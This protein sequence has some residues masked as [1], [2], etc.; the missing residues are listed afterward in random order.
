MTKFWFTEKKK[1]QTIFIF[2]SNHIIVALENFNR[3]VFT[4][5][6]QSKNKKIIIIIIIQIKS[7]TNCGWLWISFRHIGHERFFN[8]HSP[9]HFEWYSCE[10][11]NILTSWPLRYDSRQIEHSDIDSPLDNV[12][13]GDGD[14]HIVTDEGFINVWRLTLIFASSLTVTLVFKDSLRTRWI[15]VA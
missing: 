13:E 1:K 5:N 14:K 9:I 15:F 3:F 10:Q 12:G 2:Y 4:I 7:V 6:T 11:A 8:I